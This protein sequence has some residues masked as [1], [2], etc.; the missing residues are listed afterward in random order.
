MYC[1]PE[2]PVTAFE[3]KIDYSHATPTPLSWRRLLPPPPNPSL[4]KFLSSSST[5]TTTLDSQ[6]LTY[7][8]DFCGLSRESAIS[9]SQK[10]HL[11]STE[12]PSAVLGLFREYG[13]GKTDI[14]KIITK[15]PT[16]LTCDPTRSSSQSSTFSA[17][18]DSP[19]TPFRG[20]SR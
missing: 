10:L 9:A 8:I 14:S 3:L 18:S 11:K 19:A 2:A 5:T 16:L 13:F 6:T 12:K 20:S 15:I 1:P 7:L 4:P 17:A